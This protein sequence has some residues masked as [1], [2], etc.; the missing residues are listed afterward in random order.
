MDELQVLNGTVKVGDRL[1][2]ARVEY[3]AGGMSVGEVLEILDAKRVKVRVDK[4]SGMRGQR[5][6]P[7]TLEWEFKPYVKV[8]TN[9][10]HMVKL[11][12]LEDAL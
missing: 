9:P 10:S 7:E 5:V 2:V 8:Y 6:N 3:R 4:A 11:G 1:A 12:A